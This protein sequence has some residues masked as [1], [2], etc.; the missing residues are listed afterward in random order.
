MLETVSDAGGLLKGVFVNPFGF[1]FGLL[2]VDKLSKIQ[3]YSSEEYP[4]L[5]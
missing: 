5:S 4:L 1:A 2:P 3:L